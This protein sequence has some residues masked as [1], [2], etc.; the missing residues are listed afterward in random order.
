MRLQRNLSCKALP[1]RRM[2][3]SQDVTV[4]KGVV[5]AKE[6]ES[7]GEVRV[8]MTLQ[9]TNVDTE[10]KETTKIVRRENDEEENDTET[11][12][13][14]ETEV[15]MIGGRQ[16]KKAAT[17]LLRKRGIAVYHLRDPVLRVFLQGGA[18]QK[19][20]ACLLREVSQEA[21]AEKTEGVV[22]TQVLILRSGG[23]RIILRRRGN[24]A[25][26]LYHR[27]RGQRQ[28]NTEVNREV[29]KALVNEVDRRLAGTTKKSRRTNSRVDE[30]EA[31]QSGSLKEGNEARQ[32]VCLRRVVRTYPKTTM[33]QI[34]RAYGNIVQGR[35]L[36]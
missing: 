12:T 31:H 2:L 16:E 20:V 8:N 32:R 7:A 30:E 11:G 36:S 3:D 33:R 17:L 4:G 25:R 1:T 18:I 28:Q 22:E 34:Q 29:K 23:T 19:R 27:D 15:E 21:I 24:L 13:E 26:A 5:L 10:G 6:M 35:P 9:T 14:T